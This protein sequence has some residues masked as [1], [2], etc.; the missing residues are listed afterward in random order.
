MLHPAKLPSYEHERLAAYIFFTATGEEFDAGKMRPERCASPWPVRDAELDH[1]A[2]LAGGA[3]ITL[4]GRQA[5][6]LVATAGP[7]PAFWAT[8]SS[9]PKRALKTDALV[10]SDIPSIELRNQPRELFDA[11][12]K[13]RCIAVAPTVGEPLRTGFSIRLQQ[14]H[15]RRLIVQRQR[16]HH[17]G[18][19][20]PASAQNRR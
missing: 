16:T 4:V 18:P 12:T 3:V 19:L 15:R 8:S 20:A 2:V 17:R 5:A 10:P 14:L 9:S 6:H 11:A 7:S 1:V 13:L